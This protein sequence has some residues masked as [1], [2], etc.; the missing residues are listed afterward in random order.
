MAN[1]KKRKGSNKYY[2]RFTDHTGKVKEVSTHTTDKRLA[3]RKAR[4]LQSKVD[5]RKNGMLDDQTVVFERASKKALL[6]HIQEYIADCG[7]QGQAKRRITSKV[8]HL[9]DAVTFMNATRLVDLQPDPFRD[10]L[11]S[12]EVAPTTV[13]EY[14]CTVVS[15]LNWCKKDGRV[16]SNCN[17]R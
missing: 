7:T 15:F 14:R 6:E 3:E 17:D 9:N 12:L 11:Q 8:K 16:R 13:N 2:V 1:V 5:E 10:W 4:E